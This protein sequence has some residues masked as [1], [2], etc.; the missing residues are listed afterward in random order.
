MK[1]EVKFIEGLDMDVIFYIGQNQSENFHVIDMGKPNDLWFH[2]KDISS[3]H[4][5]AIIPE[6]L[7]KNEIRYIVKA[8]CLLC[9]NN[10][11]KLK[12]LKNVAIV[13]T[14]IKNI[15]KTKIAGC[16]NLKNE[17]TLII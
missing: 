5:V 6:N 12:I 4:V 3:T 1:T 14:E 15:E 16:V 17:K 8:G 10:T 9:K 7:N 2:A 11:N 13:Y